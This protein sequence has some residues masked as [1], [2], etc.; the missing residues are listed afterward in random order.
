M[1]SSLHGRRVG[2]PTYERRTRIHSVM[3]NRSSEDGARE[4]RL[5]WETGD[6]INPN[7]N[8]AKEIYFDVQFR[9]SA[10]SLSGA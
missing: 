1:Q 3:D 5:L 7:R 6:D 8:R 4:N 2:G 9:V 10:I